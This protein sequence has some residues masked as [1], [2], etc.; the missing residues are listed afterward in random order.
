MINVRPGIYKHYKGGLYDVISTC[1]TMKNN[2]INKLVLYQTLNVPQYW[3]RPLNLFLDPGRFE[4]I[5]PNFYKK[6]L[7][8]VTAFHTEE[9][10]YYRVFRN[11]DSWFCY[12][13]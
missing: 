8:G 11:K 9:E 5:G 6:E 1:H 10:I 7:Y 3:I 2:E 13:I 4:F 12:K